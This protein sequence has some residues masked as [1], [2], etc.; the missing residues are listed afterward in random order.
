MPPMRVAP[1]FHRL[2]TVAGLT[3]ACV[4]T[5]PAPAAPVTRAADSADLPTDPAALVPLLTDPNPAR[6]QGALADL[7]NL[8]RAARPAVLDAADGRDP[9]L[10]AAA[11]AVLLKLPWDRPGDPID[12]RR[13]LQLHGLLSV[14]ERADNVRRLD[15]IPGGVG[16]PAVL[17]LLREDPAPAVQWQ[18]ASLLAEHPD[19]A[20]T[21]ALRAM[22]DAPAAPKSLSPAALY[23]AARA[24]GTGNGAA[25]AGAA[26][27]RALALFRACADRAGP[28]ADYAAMSVV[29]ARLMADAG[30]RE[31]WPAA[32]AL[33][34]RRLALAGTSAAP[35]EGDDSGDAGPAPAAARQVLAIQAAY[36]PLPGFLD[37]LR[38]AAAVLP[39]DRVVL[40]AAAKMFDHA[41]APKPLALSAL[42]YGTAY[43]AGGDDA[44][45]R[46]STASELARLGWAGPAEAELRTLFL[47]AHAADADPNTQANGHLMLYQLALRTS[48][49]GLAA[50]QLQVVVDATGG[51]GL[52]RT[53]PG[54]VATPWLPAAVSAEVWRLR[55]LDA[56]KRADRP[57]MLAAVEHMLRLSD[58][59]PL[60]APDLVLALADLGRDTEIGPVFDPAYATLKT[61][62]AAA[63]ADPTAMNQL[64]WLL[65]RSGRKLDEGLK[66]AAE[67]V[68]LK[69]ENAGYLDTLAEV[70]YR[71]GDPAEAARLEARAVSLDPNEPFIKEQLAK[72]QKA[73]AATRPAA[74]N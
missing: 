36:G 30:A 73:A 58:Q 20:S 71:R 26:D 38:N 37:D 68:R 10:A 32:L 62:L 54:G 52:T 55:Y 24:V 72:F 14:A 19:P 29:Y 13:R 59:A 18:A 70:Q 63:P 45:S 41:R 57:A 51:A 3:A 27:P 34:R 40:Y 12:V 43:A 42:L 74:Q 15:R 16:R 11:R 53:D 46:L 33:A 31:D 50:E 7:V 39:G 4:G 61:A 69:P 8:G 48:R 21:A 23:A 60:V 25:A 5:A 2:L 22:A 56:K 35:P 49:P 44:E 9:R 47:L 67:A 28:G 64:A 6:R 17:R 66:L 1:G 65:A